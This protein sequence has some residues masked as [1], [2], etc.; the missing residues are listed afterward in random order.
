MGFVEFV[1][2]GEGKEKEG[3]G[4]GNWNSNVWEAA[5]HLAGLMN[6]QHGLIIGLKIVHVIIMMS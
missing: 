5:W 6:L 4:R 3:D 1:L 2:W